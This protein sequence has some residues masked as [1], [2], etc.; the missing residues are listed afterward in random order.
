MDGSIL[1]KLPPGRQSRT[2]SLVHRWIGW[3]R[4]CRC[5]SATS[6]GMASNITGTGRFLFTPLCDVRTGKVQDKTAARPSRLPLANARGS[7]VLILSRDREGAVVN[8]KTRHHTSD[9]DVLLAV[10]QVSHRR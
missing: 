10:E 7:E 5:R 8:A 6:N 3:T 1:R 4:Y 2:G 9:R